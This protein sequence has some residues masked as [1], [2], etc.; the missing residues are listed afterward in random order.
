MLFLIEYN[1]PKGKLVT[2]KRFKSSDRTKAEKERLQIELTLNREK[3]DHEVVLLEA[4]R[5]NMLKHTHA[6]YFESLR[7]MVNSTASLN[8]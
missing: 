1:R 6:R 2:F 4:E 7:G 5:E 3:I 8:S